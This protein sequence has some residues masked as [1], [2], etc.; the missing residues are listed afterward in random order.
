MQ[1]NHSETFMSQENTISKALEKLRSILNFK[2][3]LLAV[4]F[5]SIVCIVFYY[6][7]KDINLKIAYGGYG[8]QDY[9]AQKLHPEYF[10][11]N[12]PNGIL[13]YNHSLPMRAYYYLAKYCRISPSTTVYP[14]MFIQTLLFLLSVVFLTQTLFKNKFVTFISVIVISISNLAGLNL[15]RFGAGYGSLLSFPLFYGY[16]N[17]FRF[18][19]LG[20]FLKNKYILCFIFLALSIYCHVNM[21]L[22]ALAFICGYF[23]FRPRLFRDKNL[24]IGMLI[25]LVLVVPHIFLILSNSNAIT[26]GG[27]PVDQWVKST[28]IFSFHWYPITM[29]LFTKNAHREFFPFLMLCFFFFVALRY[30]DIKN[31]KT[32]KIIVGSIACLIMSLAGVGFSDIYPIPFLIKISLQRSTG[33]IT[34]LG[35]LYI[36]Y[37]LFRKID[38]GKIFNI[39]LASYSLLLLV[40]S[41]PGIAVSPLFLLLYSDIREG[42]FGSLKI[43]AYKTSIGKSCYFIMAFL[44][45]MLT[46]TCIFQ[47]NHKIAN[48]MFGHLWTPL[49]Y[50]N[51]FSG[52]DFLLKGGKFKGFPVFIYSV[53]GSSLI[54]VYKH[55]FRRNK[56]NILFINIFFVI[57]LSTVWYHERDQYLRWHNTYSKIASSYLDVQLWAKKNTPTDALFMPDPSHS[58]GWR[59][60][61]ERSSFGN[62]RE[63]G[64]CVIAY[65]PDY[66]LYQEGLKRMQEFGI[67]IEKIREEDIINSSTFIYGSKLVND[68]R[69]EF[70][71]MKEEQIQYLSNKYSIDYIVMNKQYHKNSFCSFNAA[72]ENQHYI[73]YKL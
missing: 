66:K 5:L 25:F 50:F 31:E 56:A 35:V 34:F 69:T 57:S 37:Y 36:I 18:F 20:F 46:L 16:S 33:L 72:Y 13:N 47:N 1:T 8:P 43:E 12:W 21:G 23:L 7:S 19:A 68:I 17:A 2:N 39:F 27:I 48:S 53:V 3:I 55:G 24:V 11:A 71:N 6:N 67:D 10:K 70:Y 73:I 58:Y 42:H 9:V 28:R 26:S 14:Y 52:F 64:Y 30:Q 38:N 45:L 61:S 54:I 59:D 40:F 60:F 41:K 15:S 51:P 62:L 32:L 49:Q 22:F 44:L 4:G 65:N 29:K 63:W